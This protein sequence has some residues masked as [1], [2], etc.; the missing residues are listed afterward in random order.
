L[1]DIYSV[2]SL[3]EILF[4]VRETLEQ[5]LNLVKTDVK[6]F[7]EELKKNIPL[8]IEKIYHDFLNNKRGRK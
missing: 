3:P 1:H 6:E 5:R 4:K 7:Q 2:K 8:D